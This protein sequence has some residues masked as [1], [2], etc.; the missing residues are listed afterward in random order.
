[1]TRWI[2]LSFERNEANEKGPHRC[3]PLVDPAKSG[4]SASRYAAA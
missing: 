4:V 2:A 1:M 3:E